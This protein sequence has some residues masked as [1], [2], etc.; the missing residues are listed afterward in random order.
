MKLLQVIC[1]LFLLSACQTVPLVNNR[2]AGGQFITPTCPQCGQG[3]IRSATVYQD[4]NEHLGVSVWT[5]QVAEG[6]KL[7]PTLKH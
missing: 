6:T 7:A 2:D 1:T 4:N 5:G 3:F